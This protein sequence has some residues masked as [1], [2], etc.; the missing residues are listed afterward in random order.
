MGRYFLCI[1]FLTILF[2]SFFLP[3]SVLAEE[4]ESTISAKLKS[5][6]SFELF[7]PLTAGKTMEDSTYFLKLWKEQIQGILIFDSTK[8]ADYEVMLSTKRILETEKLIK[9]GKDNLA[10]Q[11]LEK[12]FSNL[13]SARTNFSKSTKSGNDFQL[14]EINIINQLSNLNEFI[15][16]LDAYGKEDFKSKNNEIK[17]LVNEFFNDFK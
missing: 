17:K 12:A 1:S 10:V 14:A 3:V 5:G 2:L 15:P 9:E 7:W 11:T 8:K 6:G 4:N 13:S 16:S